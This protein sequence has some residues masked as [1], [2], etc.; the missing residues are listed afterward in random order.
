MP[1][2]SKAHPEAFR[3]NTYVSQ[4]M[5]AVDSGDSVLGMHLYLAAFEQAVQSN[6]FDEEFIVQILKQAWGL[7]IDLKERSMAEYIYDHLEPYLTS[8]EMLAYAESLQELALN[9]LADFGLTPNEI[10]DLG[11]LITEDFLSSDAPKLFHMEDIPEDKRDIFEKL[12]EAALSEMSS[13]A[14]SETSQKETEAS[15]EINQKPKKRAAAFEIPI[16]K[17]QEDQGKKKATK[18]KQ[19]LLPNQT[20][21]G[22]VGYETAI[23]RIR[24]LGFGIQRTDFG[25]QLI[26]SLKKQYG[27]Q[28]IPNTET[29]LFTGFSRGDVNEFMLATAA[30]LHIPIVRMMVEEGPQGLPVLCVVASPD[31]QARLGTSNPRAPLT[32]PAIVLLEDIDVWGPALSEALSEDFDPANFQQKGRGAREALSLIYMAIKSPE[33]R[34]FASASEASQMDDIFFDVLE[35]MFVFNLE[36]PTVHE[37]QDLIIHMMNQYPALPTEILSDLVRLTAHMSR[38]DIKDALSDAVNAA[39]KESI[40]QRHYQKITL[41]MLAEFISMYQPVDSKEYAELEK[42]VVNKFSE[43]LES[44]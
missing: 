34:V 27:A 29:L 25:K 12:S 23:A 37:R 42:I 3:T 32:E 6:S 18:N 8:N 30:E 19:G 26:K 38:C 35:P 1:E 11:E 44:F 5:Q 24:D 7:A 36:S 13:Q 41:A 33:I 31:S 28:H 4:A 2:N 14:E 9:K 20:F 21:D 16:K 15:K 10:E 17:K 39:F 43:F 40:S 22:L